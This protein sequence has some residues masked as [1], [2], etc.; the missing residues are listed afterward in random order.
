[1]HNPIHKFLTREHTR[2]E[3]YLDR[4]VQDFDQI[5]QEWYM[6]FR[7]GMLTHIKQEEKVLFKIAQE[8]KGEPI[9]LAAQLRLEHGALTSLLVPPPNRDL[10][11]VI[12]YLLKKHDEKE[13][14][15]GGMYDICGELTSEQTQRVL[16]EMRNMPLTPVHPNKDIPLA[17]D[18][19]KRSCARA[20]FD[21]D[22]IVRGEVDKS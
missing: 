13:E 4:A 12:R 9:P 7:V 17:W 21:Y 22:A 18:T 14:E 6:H 5:D 11:K 2:I 20:G 3:G 8:V 16:L 19:A 15:P 1:M 10:V